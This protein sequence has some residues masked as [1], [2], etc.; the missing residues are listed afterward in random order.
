MQIKVIG[1]P[2]FRP[3]TFDRLRSLFED[4][5]KLHG[6]YDEWFAAADQGR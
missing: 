6:T 4:G 3:E 1:M 5:H 2:W